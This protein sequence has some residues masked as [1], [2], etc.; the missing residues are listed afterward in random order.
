[1]RKKQSMTVVALAATKGGVGKTTLA[2]ALAVRAAQDGGKVAL[3]DADPQE[4]LWRWWELRGQP[5]SPKI[6][7]ID[8]NAEALA[9]LIAEGWRYVFIDTPPALFDRIESA[10]YVADLV[11]IPTRASAIDIEAVDD[12]VDLCKDNGKKFA[13]VLN[14]VLP[15]WG[16]LTDSAANY[17]KNHGTVLTER[18]GLRK[19]YVSAMTVGKTGAEIDRNGVAKAEIDRLWKS[20]QKLTQKAPTKSRA[21]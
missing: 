13:F 8:A 10:I 11:L 4:S 20:V 6:L 18:I 21:R 12:V 5:E 16:S 14:A 17:L 2:S 7:E 9:L 19:S 15:G 3:L 1:M